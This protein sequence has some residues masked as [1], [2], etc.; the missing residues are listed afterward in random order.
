MTTD[1]RSILTSAYQTPAR[2]PEATLLL[3]HILVKFPEV[4]RALNKTRRTK[5]LHDMLAAGIGHAVLA[6]QPSMKQSIASLTA[7]GYRVTS[8]QERHSDTHTPLDSVSCSRAHRIQLL[9]AFLLHAEDGLTDEQAMLVSG[10]P[11][12][13][14]WWRRCS[15]LR[16]DRLV[17][18]MLDDHDKRITRAGKSGVPRMVCT[19]TPEGRAVAL[20]VKQ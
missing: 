18:P 10:V 14:C 20:S 4:R 9:L 8:Q 6:S 3:H 17:V 15:E 11:A 16:A 12:S 7:A 19:I 1:W 5:A 2:V 13:S